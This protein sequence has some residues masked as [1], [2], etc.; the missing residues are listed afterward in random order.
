M[1][2]H[3]VDFSSNWL[4]TDYTGRLWV[5][6]KDRYVVRWLKYVVEILTL[7][8][9][10]FFEHIRIDRVALALRFQYSQSKTPDE[11]KKL[12]QIVDALLMSRPPIQRYRPHLQELQQFWQTALT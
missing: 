3:R 12:Y 6:P 4:A 9:A 7:G 2:L 10:S 11:K 1:E 8:C 5:R